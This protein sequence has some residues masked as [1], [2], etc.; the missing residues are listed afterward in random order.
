MV[1]ITNEETG[2]VRT[3]TSDA[4]G[5]Y[6]LQNLSSG[7]FTLRVESPGFRNGERTG[8]VLRAGNCEIVNVNLGLGLGMSETVAVPL[9]PP[10]APPANL[11]DRKKPFTYVV[12]EREG[13]TTFQGIARLV[14]GDRKKWVQIFEANRAVVLKPGPIPN[15]TAIYI[16]PGK[17]A[18]PKLVA[19][20]TPAYPTSG[21]PGDVVLD[22][23]LGGDGAVNDV[24]VIDGDPVLADAAVRAVKQW[25]YQPLVVNGTVVDKFVV[26]VTFGRNGKVK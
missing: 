18:V 21:G 17:R 19:K 22:V 4:A 8:I 20:V 10:P 2:T 23:L 13:D 9:K 12:G 1:T 11:Y 24:R 7:R 16:P 5:H 26:V 15:G 25:K 3:V 14:Y 6:A